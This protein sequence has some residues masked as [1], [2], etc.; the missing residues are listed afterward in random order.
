MARILEQY[1]RLPICVNSL[2]SLNL[3]SSRE[4]NR[5]LLG[6]G[7]K[8]DHD[9]HHNDI[10]QTTLDF[11]IR[12]L[13]ETSRSRYQLLVVFANSDKVPITAVSLLWSQDI[14]F[15]KKTFEN[16]VHGG[17]MIKMTDARRYE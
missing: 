8:L 7:T 12:S 4:V 10:L 2:R 9:M 5:Q 17:L 1:H 13:D 6:L 15:I 11:V 14:K 16:L 3:A